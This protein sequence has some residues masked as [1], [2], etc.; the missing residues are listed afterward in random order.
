MWHLWFLA[1]GVLHA[2]LYSSPPP[3]ALLLASAC[4]LLVLSRRLWFSLPA[5]VLAGLAF[6]SW[7]LQQKSSAQLP[8]EFEQQ[9]FDLRFQ[10]V[11][12][13]NRSG[14]SQ[15]FLAQVLELR[16]GG[17]CPQLMN[18][19]LRLS[20]YQSPQTPSGW[21]TLG[22][23]Q[24]WQA[25][26]KLRRPRGFVNPGG[27]DYHAWLLAQDVIATGYLTRA[28]EYLGESF[29]LAAERSAIESRLAE[30]HASP[31]RRFWSALL[32]GEQAAIE[33]ADWAT[34]QA[35][36]TVHLLV[37]SGLHISLVATWCF[38]LGALAARCAGLLHRGSNL[39]LMHCLP[40]VCASLGAAYYAALAGFT[41]PTQRALVACLVL[42]LCRLFGLNFSAFTLLGMAALAVGLME[43]F[44]WMSSGF[45]LSFLAVAVLFYSLGGRGQVS[46][47][48]ALVRAQMVLS[49][50]LLLPLLALGQGTSLLS[51]IANLVA[52]PVVSV[53]LTPLLL[54]AALC[55]G[56]LPQV[57]QWLLPWMDWIFGYLWGFLEWV[58]ARPVSLWWPAKPLSPVESGVAAMGVVL[59]LAPAGLQV[60]CLGAVWLCLAL[61]PKPDAD[62]LLRLTVLEVGQG[63]AVV[64]ETPGQTWLYDTGP[65]FSEDFDAGS[66]IIAPYLRS[67]GVKDLSLMISH[68]DMDH[69]G[70]AAGIVSAFPIERL[71]YGEPLATLPGLGEPCH[72]GQSWQQGPVNWRVLWP[73]D[74]SKTGNNASCTLL[75]TL[76]PNTEPVRLL[77]PGDIDSRVEMQLL[78]D[79]Q[80]PVD[81]VLAPHHGS[82][83][84]SSLVFV[85][86]LAAR[87]V[88]FSAGF[89]NRYGHPHPRVVQRWRQA[90][91][92]LYNTATDGAL[93]F[94]WRSSGL[95]VERLRQS[96]RRL[97]H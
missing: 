81:W 88:V 31:Y 18:G 58:Q 50:G 54:V 47:V 6:G 49:V 7:Q 42:M 44:A 65:Q 46:A 28:G 29:S 71:L 27:F 87:H 17:R 61:L 24:I 75:L 19:R 35:T 76:N 4:A 78:A 15:V 37:I 79:L 52:V 59:L 84:S 30:Q 96:R 16:C 53:I 34:L 70:G 22:A 8:A 64:L 51:P 41:I 90:G 80:A 91:A 38:F 72:R 12:I 32:I 95:E 66:R 62:Y 26:V 93:V 74:S 45:W 67:R 60:R 89:N 25:Q 33:Q 82:N 92:E 63:T 57:T 69:A 20:W 73:P 77:L 85:R 94:T 48:G 55:S 43:P 97:W 14:R 13:P 36:G 9:V 1:A 68:G 5:C 23:G 86:Q 56:I 11:S 2:P 83:S 3:V 40:P 21:Q 10:V 39:W